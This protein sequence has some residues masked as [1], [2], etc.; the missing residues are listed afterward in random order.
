MNL[1]TIISFILIFVLSATII[2]QTQT[3]TDVLVQQED[4]NRKPT[5]EEDREARRMV[6]AFSKRYKET[7]DIKPLVREFF[8]KDFST[9]LKVC[10]STDKCRGFGKDFFQF[11]E[12]SVA[13]KT[14]KLDLL[15]FY[16][17][18]MNLYF[19]HYFQIPKHL[20]PDSIESLEE[21]GLK[22]ILR[23]LASLIKDDTELLKFASDY[24]GIDIV[25]GVERDE[26]LNNPFKFKSVNQLRSFLRNLEKLDDAF[27]KL[28]RKFRSNRQKEKLKTISVLQPKD[29]RIYAE[30]IGKEFFN[31][32]I[33]TRIIE[34]WSAFDMAKS[35]F[36]PFKFDLLREKGK[37]RIIAV[38]PPMD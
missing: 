16:G 26:S 13:R 32:P 9:R 37:L 8:I 14:T 28:E 27:R 31:F 7:Q 35:S 20:N 30:P 3:K 19:L 1:R 2:S 25:T 5:P 6:V 21:I 23:E 18:L 12:K 38:Y 15:R 22:M 11:G 24:F 4:D 17:G 29:L 33:G 36:F 34:V 10:Y